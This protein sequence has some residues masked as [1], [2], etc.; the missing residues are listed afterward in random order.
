MVK[1]NGVTSSDLP[2]KTGVPQGSILGP[3]LF[4]MFVNDLPR[5]IQRSSCLMY[6]DD[7][8]LYSSSANPSNIEF[9]LN[10]DLVNAS[11]WFERNRLTLNIK[12][13]K[14]MVIH[15][16]NMGERFAHVNIFIQG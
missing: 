11:N 10:R 7:T 9:A 3:L 6:A 2:I 12:K 13:T 4:I 16:S 5:S 8:T 1:I 15:P 14:F